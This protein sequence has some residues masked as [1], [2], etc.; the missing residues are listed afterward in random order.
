M[1]VGRKKEVLGKVLDE[2]EFELVV[3]YTEEL[4]KECQNKKEEEENKPQE[5]GGDNARGMVTQSG[6]KESLCAARGS[7]RMGSM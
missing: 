7:V 6:A 5:E 3:E 2:E 1:G 4:Y